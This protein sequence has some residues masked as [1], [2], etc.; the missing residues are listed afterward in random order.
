[1]GTRLNQVWN[2]DDVVVNDKSATCKES[3]GVSTRQ[4]SGGYDQ[5]QEKQ[6]HISGPSALDQLD[7]D[8]SVS[9]TILK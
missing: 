8:Q 5:V 4:M 1:M 9:L 3:P 2:D 7:A 6:D